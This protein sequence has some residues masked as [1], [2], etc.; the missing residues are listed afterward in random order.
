MGRIL[1]NL[2]KRDKL[3]P[4]YYVYLLEHHNSRSI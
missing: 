1:L 2:G 4:G 3:Y